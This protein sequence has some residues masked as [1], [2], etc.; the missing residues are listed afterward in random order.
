MKRKWLCLASVLLLFLYGCSQQIPA[1][2]EQSGDYSRTA[3]LEAAKPL[4]YEQWKPLFSLAGVVDYDLS[5]REGAIGDGLTALGDRAEHGPFLM[6]N[7]FTNEKTEAPHFYLMAS[8]R[9]SA[10]SLTAEMDFTLTE[11]KMLSPDGKGQCLI[12]KPLAELNHKSVGDTIV[13]KNWLNPKKKV[14]VKITGI[15]SGPEGG[16]IMDERLKDALG[17]E[18]LNGI[19]VTV[20]DLRK[21]TEGTEPEGVWRLSSLTMDAPSSIETVREEID[22]MGLSGTLKLYTAEE[23]MDRMMGGGDPRHRDDAVE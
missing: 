19:F 10:E 2:Q 18:P 5:G 17:D 4:P 9:L 16:E 15:Y 1:P 14:K 23:L 7:P 8:R 20:A 3:Y 13:L 11:G 6:E 22:R 12:S 21:L